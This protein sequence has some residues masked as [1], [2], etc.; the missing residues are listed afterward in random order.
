MHICPLFWRVSFLLVAP[1]KRTLEAGG[2]GKSPPN[3][4]P[5]RIDHKIE[6][7]RR[8]N[9]IKM[10]QL[11]LKIDVKQLKTTTFLKLQSV[12][13]KQQFRLPLENN[14]LSKKKER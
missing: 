4:G 5:P 12:N 6:I 7:F 13:D 3:W 9:W 14:K 11:A 2:K 8:L 1:A 10:E